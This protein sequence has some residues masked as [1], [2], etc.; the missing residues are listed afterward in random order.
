MRSSLSTR[1]GSLA[2][3]AVIATTGAMAAAGAAGATTAHARRLPTHLSIATRRAVE[4]RRHVTLIGGRLTSLTFPLKG[5]LIFLDRVTATHKLIIVGR[6]WTNRHGTVVFVVAPKV[7]AHY[8]LVFPGT[9]NF[10]SSHSRVVTV[11]P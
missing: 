7:T 2:A 11:R 3:A 8:A 4:H 5:K 6:E 1:A 10:H 9:P